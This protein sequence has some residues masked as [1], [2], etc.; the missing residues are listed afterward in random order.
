MGRG[1]RTTIGL[2]ERIVGLNGSTSLVNR[3]YVGE[4]RDDQKEGQAIEEWVCT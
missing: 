1:A 3:R 2:G 4:W